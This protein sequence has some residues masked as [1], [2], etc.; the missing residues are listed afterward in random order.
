MYFYFC[1]FELDLHTTI[2]G[3][4]GK[5]FFCIKCNLV[6]FSVMK[7]VVV[8]RQF[9]Q[10]EPEQVH[11]RQLWLLCYVVSYVIRLCVFIWSS[12]FS[13][14]TLAALVHVF[15]QLAL[16]IRTR[17]DVCWLLWSLGRIV[18]LCTRC[19]RCGLLLQMSHVAWSVCLPVC[20]CVGH[21]GKLCII[22]WAS[23]DEL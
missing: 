1:R 13:H 19:I 9:V 17:F 16:Y 14:H 15:S 10:Y 3:L 7:R 6:K 21:T 4:H 23:R 18:D 12:A 11:A 5:F 2:N 22:G 20:L 8:V